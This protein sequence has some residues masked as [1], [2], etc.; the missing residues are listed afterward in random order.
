M[1]KQLSMA[2]KLSVSTFKQLSEQKST[3]LH[4]IVKKPV[5]DMRIKVIRA[6]GKVEHHKANQTGF[7]QSLKRKFKGE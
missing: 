2:Y 4:G 6:N 1:I 7:M 3:G 5:V